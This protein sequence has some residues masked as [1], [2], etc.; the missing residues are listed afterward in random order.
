MLALVEKY[1]DFSDVA[2]SKQHD[3][4]RPSSP[5]GKTIVS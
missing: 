1:S 3:L 5:S 4:G 2:A